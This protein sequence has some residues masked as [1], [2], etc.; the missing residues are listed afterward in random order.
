MEAGHLHSE[1]KPVECTNRQ[2][3]ETLRL[4]GQL[5]EIKGGN[6]YRVRAF[7]NGA[8]AVDRL[9]RPVAELSKDEVVALGGVGEHLAAVVREVC[10]TGSS[11]EL[12]ALRA[13]IPPSLLELLRIEGVGP[14]TVGP[15]LARTRS[16]LGRGTPGGDGEGPGPADEGL[17][18]QERGRDPTGGRAVRRV[19]AAHEPVD[20]RRGDRGTCGGPRAG[21]V[22]GRGLVPPREGDGRRPRHRQLRGSR[23]PEPAPSTCCGRGDRVGGAPDIDPVPGGAGRRPVHDRRRIRPH[24][25]LLHRVEAVQHQA[26][27]PGPP[28]GAPDQR[29]RDRGPGR[30]G[31]PHLSDRGGHAQ[32]A[33]SAVHSARAP[34][35][36]GRDRGGRAR[37]VAGAGRRRRPSRR[38]PCP[39][40]LV[41]RNALPR[42]ARGRGGAAGVRIPGHHGPLGDPEG[43]PRPLRAGA[44]PSSGTR[45]R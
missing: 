35:G 28:R 44:S 8:D 12:E 29:V 17:R 1:V 26:P 3:A 13:E 27:R 11:T 30:N 40:E 10:E 41:G 37:S 23:G 21:H 18:C 19:R 2:V 34:R 32:V 4:I 33:R 36:R 16:H 20:G 39:L 45:S 42:R 25:P 14:K 22:R 9:T 43:R 38:P 6:P 31:S 15:A 5:L 7:T 24:A